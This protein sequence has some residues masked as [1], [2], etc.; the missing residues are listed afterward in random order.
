[1]PRQTFDDEKDRS[2]FN[3]F[4]LLYCYIWTEQNRKKTSAIIEEGRKLYKSE[5]ASW[6]GTD[7]FLE[8]FSD[9]KAN[10][11]GYFSYSNNNVSKCIFFSKGDSPKVI[12]TISFDS[13]YNTKTAIAD[14]TERDFTNQE[15]DLYAI[16]KT[17]LAE[18]RTDTLFKT[19]KNTNLNIIPLINKTDKKVYVLT[20]PQKDG[21]V[22]IGNDYLLTFDKNN[23]LCELRVKFFLKETK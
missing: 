23:K 12:G 21:V 4:V 20:G 6:Y 11:S 14:G 17:A 7:I 16:R 22:I 15:L 8:K 2:H 10:I 13:T 5:M 19:Y 9:R 1:M 3:Q 18:I